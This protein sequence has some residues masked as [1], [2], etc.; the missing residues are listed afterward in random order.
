MEI[1][2]ILGFTGL[3]AG[4]MAGLLGIGGGFIVVPL[5]LLVLP[6][7]GIPDK[8]VSH[9]AIGTSL[10]CICIT[11]ISSSY[12]HHRKKAVNFHVL[13]QVVPGLICGAIA[14][15]W[16]AGIL[17]GLVLVF[18][19]V[20]GALLTAIY[21]MMDRRVS[22]TEKVTPS[23]MYFS[24]ANFTGI[25]SALIGIGGGSILVPFLVF[26]GHSMVGSVGTAAA[27]G[28]PI[29]LFGS[30]GFVIS[31]WSQAAGIPLSSGFVY[32]PALI[33]I[34]IFSMISAP[35]G[36][37]LAH[38]LSEKRLK[39]VFAVFLIFTSGQ[40]IYSQWFSAA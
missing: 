32:W 36:A 28:F 22:A 33:G 2:L 3:M 8:L 10:A 23:W 16:L 30:I 31:G 17:S 24:Y 40:I 6:T 15:S 4:F 18:I 27:G 25:I 9:F 37:K 39:L 5:L 21:L 20:T 29:A 35:L 26:R 12:A 34:V 38:F 19:F 7:I 14:G 11:S 13:K 1:W